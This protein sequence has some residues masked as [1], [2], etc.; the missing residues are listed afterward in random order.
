ADLARLLVGAEAVVDLAEPVEELV[1]DGVGALVAD[2]DGDGHPHHHLDAQGG[3]GLSALASAAWSD[4]RQETVV[5]VAPAMFWSF[6]PEEACSCS[7]S[8]WRSGSAWALM[9]FDFGVC[10]G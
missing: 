8:P 5:C 7:V 6:V 2:V 4:S 3:Y 10:V 9:Y 1:E